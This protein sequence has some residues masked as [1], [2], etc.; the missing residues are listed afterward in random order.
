MDPLP[1]VFGQQAKVGEN[2]LPFGIG[3]VA[4]V[5]IVSDHTRNYVAN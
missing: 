1:G 4:G 2:K 5:G 3:D